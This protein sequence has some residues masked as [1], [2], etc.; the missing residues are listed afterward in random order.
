MIIGLTATGKLGNGGFV[1]DGTTLASQA[2]DLAVTVV[3][4]DGTQQT[5]NLTAA[6]ITLVE[7]NSANAGTYHY[8]LNSVGLARLQDLLGETVT[9]DQTEINQVSGTITI[10]QE[11]MSPL[12]MTVKLRPVTLRGFRQRLNLEIRVDQWH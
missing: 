2:N 7:K 8:L 12:F 5:M 3:L 1:Y 11:A 9:I 6:D 10:T 4:S